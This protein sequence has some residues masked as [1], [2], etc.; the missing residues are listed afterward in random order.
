MT[1][2]AMEKTCSCR[3]RQ[4]DM[5]RELAIDSALKAYRNPSHRQKLQ[6]L[7]DGM[8][9]V[10]KIAAGESEALQKV[11]ELRNVPEKLVLEASKLYLQNILT[12]D[13][14]NNFAALGLNQDASASDIK[15]HKRW[16]LKWLHP[17]RNPSK[18]ESALFARVCSASAALQSVTVA[19]IVDVKTN[20]HR[21]SKRAGKHESRARRDVMKSGQWSRKINFLDVA[22]NIAKPLLGAILIA[23]SFTI[24]LLLVL[25]KT[26]THSS[27]IR[28]LTW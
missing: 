17:D 12:R 3:R 23:A 5:E 14:N 2:T 24:L 13:V 28:L 9:D 10:I 16:L 25:S 4:V 26:A 20:R 11:I 7:P 27:T 18:W 21:P 6:Q 19:P 15:D 22:K 8:L 1:I